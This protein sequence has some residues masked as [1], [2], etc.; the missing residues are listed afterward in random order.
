MAMSV[1]LSP[2]VMRTLSG[3]KLGGRGFQAVHQRS[4]CWRG[5]PSGDGVEVQHLEVV[6][7]VQRRV[8]EHRGLAVF[9][10]AAGRSRV[11][12]VDEGLHLGDIVLSS[13]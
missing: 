2:P 12:P 6:D 4:V 13:E 5:L 11:A 10:A 9:V 7:A 8:A 1:M 3:V